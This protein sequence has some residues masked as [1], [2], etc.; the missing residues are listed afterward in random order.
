MGFDAG[1]ITAHLDLNTDDFNAKADEVEEKK[2]DLAKPV[3]TEVTANTDD[4]DEKLDELAAKKDEAKKPVTFDIDADGEPA[5]AE[6][7]ATD[8]A[9]K[10]ELHDPTITPELDA[11]PLLAEA[12]AAGLASRALLNDSFKGAGSMGPLLAGMFDGGANTPGLLASGLQSLGWSAADA[13]ALVRN[14][15]QDIF[16]SLPP[17]S[18]AAALVS[19]IL[20]SEKSFAT[21]MSD[22]I[23]SLTSGEATQIASMYQIAGGEK[24]QFSTFASL[25]RDAFGSQAALGSGTPG[26]ALDII[27]GPFTGTDSGFW[28]GRETPGAN[29]YGSFGGAVQGLGSDASWAEQFAAQWKGVSSKAVSDAQASIFKGI[30]D[31]SIGPSSA[32]G[33]IFSGKSGIA[34]DISKA[35]KKMGVDVGKDFTDAMSKSILDEAKSSTSGGGG[36]GGFLGGIGNSIVGG[37]GS[38][39]SAVSGISTP[40]ASGLLAAPLIVPVLGAVG[41]ATGGAIAGTSIGI[42][43]LL[44]GLVP[45]ILDLYHGYSAYS[46]QK[47]GTSTAGLS[48]GNIAV[49]NSIGN[50]ITGAKDFIQ[51][52]ETQVNPSILEFLDSAGK[53]LPIIA[54][55]WK[56]AATN[57]QGF[58]GS[59]DRG[60]SS[61]GFSSFMASMTTDVGPIMSEF[62]KFVSN[63]T[64]AFGGFLTLFGGPA[65]QAVGGWFDRVSGK[66]DN[67]LAH[68][69][70]SP[71][72]I[73][74]MTQAFNFVGSIGATIF[75]SLKGVGEGLAPIGLNMMKFLTPA[76]SGLA[77]AIGAIPPDYFTAL[78]I[79][80]ASLAAVA[81]GPWALLAAAVLAV[82]YGITAIS[83]AQKLNLSPMS[84]QNVD[85]AFAGELTAPGKRTP[86][87]NAALQQAALRGLGPGQ[88]GAAYTGL[89]AAAWATGNPDETPAQAVHYLQGH[90]TPGTVAGTALGG[91]R[92]LPGETNLPGPTPAQIAALKKALAP[93]DVS[94]WTKIE[95]Q[96][97]G[98]LDA[99]GR[100]I[101]NFVGTALGYYSQYSTDFNHWVGDGWRDM[102]NWLGNFNKFS[103]EAHKDIMQWGHDAEN[104]LDIARHG[105]AHQFDNITSDLGSFATNSIP[106]AFD[107]I[108]HGFASGFTTVTTDIANFVTKSIPHAFSAIQ[109]A[110]SGAFSGAGTWLVGAGKAIINGLIDGMN[111]VIGGLN[112]A[113][114][115]IPLLGKLFPTIPKIPHFDDGGP[116]LG[117]VGAPQLA[118]V[119]GGEFVMSRA[120]LAHGG[121][122]GTTVNVN[123]DARGATNPL[124]TEMSARSGVV[125]VLPQLR[126][127][128]TGTR[129]A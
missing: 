115:S 82:G 79:G 53:M 101:K 69:T 7:K 17:G 127:A 55:F 31:G 75:A 1:K 66:L 123:V 22:G 67:F 43:G 59:V 121:A 30:Q 129:A 92:R 60:M 58:F 5:I 35:A 87:E 57:L 99:V 74:G 63:M 48:S 91:Q 109:S 104:D 95:R 25:A 40:V 93:P 20:P 114:P 23:Y 117:P 110:I 112:A 38:A 41:A 105:I 89:Q 45:G 108:R 15:N 116:V 88:I 27:P 118:V 84:S 122:G 70:L 90:P 2:D 16:G 120:M 24:G 42:G 128:I 62:G 10:R 4:A 77:T 72:F 33:A 26:G 50:L 44:A 78:G 49:G 96:I 19:A 56:T 124:A 65:A 34:D 119:H 9:V 103:T 13:K 52:L 111:A 125:A 113:D 76:F 61:G 94:G 80:L 47:S 102:S 98:P 37:A 28:N 64:G 81:L 51:P 6:A 14:I 12:E 68:A 8:E 100:D 85:Q 39:F 107:T 106:H 32:W 11:A 46:D 97:G 73:A 36:I 86:A 21:A 83:S 54:P 126:R 3:E 29:V 71:A 18:S